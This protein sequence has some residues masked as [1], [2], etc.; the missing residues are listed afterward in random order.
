VGGGGKAKARLR[1]APRLRNARSCLLV[2]YVK[3]NRSSYNAALRLGRCYAARYNTARCARSAGA[4]AQHRARRMVGRQ[5]IWATSSSARASI[6]PA[7]QRTGRAAAPYQQPPA[8]Q[9]L[10]RC[11][12]GDRSSGREGDGVTA[13][14]LA[15]GPG[16]S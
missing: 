6:L 15:L 13:A 16:G 11:R 3:R 4:S 7:R 2:S 5:K 1:T 8:R 9:T 12:T 10:F 14:T